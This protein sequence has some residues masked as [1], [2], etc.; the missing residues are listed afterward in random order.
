MSVTQVIWSVLALAALLLVGLALRAERRRFA[1]R[2]KAGA[3]LPGAAGQPA[4]RP[5]CRRGGV[6]ARARRPRPGS[7]GRALPADVLAGAAGLFRPALA[8]RPHGHTR[9]E[10]RR[11]GFD[12]RQRPADGDTP[13]AAGQHGLALGVSTRPGCTANAA[14][15]GSRSAACPPHRGTPALAPARHRRGAHRTLAG[16][17]GR[18]GR[19]HR[20]GTGR[21]I[22]ADGRQHR[23]HPVPGRRG[24][25][26]LPP[27]RRSR[28]AL[29]HV[30][31]GRG[32]QPAPFRLDNVAH[33]GSDPGGDTGPDL[34][35]GRLRISGPHPA[36]FRDRRTTLGLGQGVAVR[37]HWK[38][39]R[40]RSRP[41]P[42]CRRPTATAM[43]NRW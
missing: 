3:W 16:A 19:A 21:P 31:A 37:A 40:S 17:V 32:G 13:G 11:I 30:L 33:G 41:I 27:C 4:H 7:A 26:C 12:S 8:R 34:D 28:P 10:R 5:A 14:Q 25:P 43:R 6:A 15:P 29:A 38:A 42:A 1:A 2:G 35:A 24:L 20:M 36:R 23:Q 39:R 18:Q 22:P 9:P